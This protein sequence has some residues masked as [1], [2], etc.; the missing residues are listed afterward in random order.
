MHG[1]GLTHLFFLPPWAGVIELWHHVSPASRIPCGLVRCHL[2]VVV[3]GRLC[4]TTLQDVRMWRCFEHMSAMA[5]LAYA[6]WENKD[7]TKLKKD[8]KG[9][10]TTVNTAQ[11]SAVAAA[12][13]E[14]VRA[15]RDAAMS[16]RI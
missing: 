3:D 10:Y 9:D 5:G 15:R 6:R 13:F 7:K 8:R 4:P 16:A 12:L 14:S 1:A 11:F 2:R